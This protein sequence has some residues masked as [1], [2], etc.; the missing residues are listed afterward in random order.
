MNAAAPSA[1]AARKNWP[2]TASALTAALVPVELVEVP[3]TVAP[4]VDGVPLLFAAEAV[5]DALEVVRDAVP[6]AV[7]A[8]AALEVAASAPVALAAAVEAPLVRY[9]GAATAVEGSTSAPTPQGMA[10]PSGCVVLGAATTFPSVLP[11]ANRVVQVRLAA[12]L[13]VNW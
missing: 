2:S 1:T 7:E 13:A 8:A 12:P 4:A 11:M 5:E 10:W 6:A 9:E 3:L